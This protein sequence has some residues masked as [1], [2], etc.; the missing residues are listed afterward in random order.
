MLEFIFA[1]LFSSSTEVDDFFTF[2]ENI[3]M[4]SVLYVEKLDIY[5]NSVLII[6]EACILEVAA[7]MSVVL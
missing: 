2:Q 5:R 4:Q 1:V 7:V 3:R 6:Q